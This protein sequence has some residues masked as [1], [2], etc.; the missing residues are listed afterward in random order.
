MNKIIGIILICQIYSV[1]AQIPIFTAGMIQNNVYYQDIPNDTLLVQMYST[2]THTFDLNSDGQTDFIMTRSF[3]QSAG[4]YFNDLTIKSY[5]GAKIITNNVRQCYSNPI[6][7]FNISKIF[8]AGDTINSNSLILKDT[9]VYIGLD[10]YITGSGGCSSYTWNH[11]NNNFIGV[12]IYEDSVPIIGWIRL[13]EIYYP[14]G[15]KVV[16]YDYCLNKCCTS[17]ID[18]NFTNSNFTIFPNPTNSKI[19]ITNITNG[20]SPTNVCIFNSNGQQILCDNIGN[21]NSL[22]L[23]VHLIPKGLYYIRIQNENII[24]N[25]KLI[26]L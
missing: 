18:E 16:I 20:L 19:T 1:N 6:S 9:L 4:L 21:K 8:I 25:K 23:D 24:E 12:V 2:F 26:I 5:N 3:L 13:G 14:P 11:I 10:D 17:K 22:E 15:N 7:F